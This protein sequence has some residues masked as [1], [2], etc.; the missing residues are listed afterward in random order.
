VKII[1]NVQMYSVGK[2]Q[3]FQYV[4]AG[5]AYLSIYGST[6]ALFGP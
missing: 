2:I 4:K 5:G 6:A 1:R 3:E